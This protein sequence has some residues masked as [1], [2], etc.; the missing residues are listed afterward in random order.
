[1]G[2]NTTQDAFTL[3]V[4]RSL[5]EAIPAEMAEVLKRTSYHPI[6]NEV[7]DFST[8]LLSGSGELVASSMGVTVHLGALELCANA[9]INHFGFESLSPGDVLIHNNPY[10]GGTHLPDVDILVPV[11]HREKLVAFAVARGHHGDI[12]GANAG[13]F[14]GDTT[15]IFQ[16]G[17]RIPPTKL[18]DAG[19]LNE[20]VKNLLL[21]NVRVPQFTWGDLQAQIAGCRLGERRIQEMFD[22]YGAETLNE[23]MAWS[24]DYSEQLMRAEIEKIPDGAYTFEDYLDNDGVDK[25]KEVKVHVKVTVEGSNITFDFSGSDPQ[26][27]GP[28]NCVYG[29]VCSATYCAMF[30]LTDPAIPKNHGCYRPINIIA[31]EGLVI[32]ARFPAPVVSGNTETSSRIVDT[33]I[34]ALAR[35]IPEKVT[36]SDSGTATAHIAGGY[37]PRINNYYAWYLG[38]DPCAWG[39]RATKDGFECAGGPRI[40]GHVSQVPMEVFETRYPYFVEEYAFATDSGGPG[41]FRGGLSG[42]TVIRPMG[43]DCEIGGA[44]DRCV[45]PPYGIFGGMPGLHGE[46]KIIHKDGSETPIDRAGGE[47][48]RDGEV[49]YFRAPGGGGYGDP[50]DR[51]PD[52]LQHDIDNEYVS[53]ESAERDYGAV[54]DRETRKIDRKATEARRKQL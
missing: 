6:F 44:N 26:V 2:K 10:P 51:D 38:A 46:N 53:I 1:M 32:N 48:A 14:A 8:A 13:S 25:E 23:M 5:M 15:S 19:D 16:E 50:L 43:H 36:G 41:R 42:I 47:V 29:V 17:V 11:F 34:G 7:L 45:I 37:D 3:G 20:G 39:A 28:A 9:V 31:P 12:G 54:V 35:V 18:Y 21:A 40:G 49:L 27:K 24:M 30:N 22:K 33:I 4:L 52:Y